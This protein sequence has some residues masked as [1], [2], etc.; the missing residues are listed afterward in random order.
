MP[1]PKVRV[2]RKKETTPTR[3]C[4]YCT[5]P[6]ST[7]GK[8]ISRLYCDSLCRDRFNNNKD[9]KRQAAIKWRL[10]H[11][12]YW[13]AHALKVKAINPNYYIQACRNYRLKN[14][15]AKQDRTFKHDKNHKGRV[16]GRKVM[17]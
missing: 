9:Y 6:F 3:V 5:S 4:K 15:L 1:P 8:R 17:I 11:P 12:G 10:A 14:K 2:H 16:W 7:E 13:Q